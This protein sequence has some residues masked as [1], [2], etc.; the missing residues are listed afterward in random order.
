MEHKAPS[1]RSGALRGI[2][3]A[4]FAVGFAVA[5]LAAP[6]AGTVEGVARN[7]KQ[8]AVAGAALKLVAQDGSVVASVTTG[9]DGSYSFKGLSPGSYTLIGD[10]S[11]VGTGNADVTVA[12]DA[13]TNADVTLL[14][15]AQQPTEEVTVTAQRLEAARINIEP[16]VGA[17][18]YSFSSASI[19]N[20][21]GGADLP[22]NQV[23][24]QAPGVD[25]DNLANGA[26]HIRNEHLEVQYRINGIILPEGVS[27]FGQGLDPRFMNSMEL[28]T[29]TLPAEYGL[30]VAG[31]VDIQTKSGL[32]QPG[33]S[34]EMRG[35]S[36]GTVQPSFSYGGSVAG[37]NYYV[38]ADNLE[39]T[40]G[41]DA[42][43]PSYDAKHDDTI[44]THAFVYLDKIIDSASKVAFV[45]GTFQGQFQ[46]PNNPGQ[47]PLY[48]PPGGFAPIDG[49]TNYDSNDLSEHQ[50]E[51]N[52]YG[53][54]SYL[55]SEEDFD[56]QI[57]AF[58]K[59]GDLH[60]HPDSLGDIFFN[61]VSQDA[62]RQSFANGIQADGSYKLGA[63][64][65]LRA[66]MF[67]QAE[68]A[69]SDTTSSVLP[70]APG[71]CVSPLD[72]VA[73]GCP[74]S[75]VATYGS[76]PES[77]VQ[78]QEKTGWLY[79]AYAQ[80]EWHVLPSVT[81]NYGGRFDV[82]NEYTMESQISPRLNTVWKPTDT[83]TV[84][85]GYANYFTPPP[86]E[87]VSTSSL[88]NP[89]LLSSSGSCATPGPGPSNTGT[90][91]NSPVKAER[92]HV[93]DVGATQEVIPGLKVGIDAFY[94]YAR[95][96]LDEGQFG[97]PVI[98]TPFNYHVGYN[99]GVELTTSYDKGNFSY[100][101]NLSIGEEKAEGISSAQFNFGST[102]ANGCPESDLQ[103]ADTHLVNTDHSERMIA[104][105]GIS[106]LWL[107]T[108]YSTDVIAG[109]GLRTMNPGDCFNQG[110]V[111]SYEQ[112]NL[113]V[114]HKFDVPYGG[115]I[116]LRADIINVL[117][118]VYLI[119]SQTGVGVFAP[120]YGP[121][122]SFFV[123][124]KKDF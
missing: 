5:A 73:A 48:G 62:L 109:S 29:G 50:V 85:A 38:S 57:S 111:P 19:A 67:I 122:R 101:G 100:Y 91:Q 65:T 69:S 44:Q 107:G 16:Q 8:Q 80:D 47:T 78:D 37:Y 106:Y 33:G 51:G 27:F 104:S 76:T 118:E 53:I 14:A 42:V 72:S 25:Q 2:A 98:L 54:L 75:G 11:G 49:V 105:A 10:K 90:C 22:L 15:Q 96:L 32:F 20:L 58:T 116:E 24:L 45:G 64:H 93:F 30:R 60:F 87:L 94:K 103:Y 83:T 46:I 119:R 88:L 70:I 26:I 82:V 4:V 21:P 23:L 52:S 41:I 55:R 59:Y 12:G 3:A 81:V 31:V 123:S 79:S 102:P 66:G 112:V 9:P 39:S 18:T 95:N 124:I 71:G 99:K 61:G 43:T 74:A 120:A 28:I 56:A 36:Y 6:P 63:D 114:S 89:M 40:H 34:V 108:R 92:S 7:A 121:R 86:F 17:S 68:K 117:D 77:I 97:A 13:G 1:M 35:G 110:T 113:G 115:P 84:H